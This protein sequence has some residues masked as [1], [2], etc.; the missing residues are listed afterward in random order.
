[1]PDILVRDM[2]EADEYFVSTCSHVNE[3]DRL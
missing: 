3:S 1:M 2:T